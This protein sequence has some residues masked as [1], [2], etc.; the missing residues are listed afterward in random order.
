MDIS[1]QIPFS[2]PVS[3]RNVTKIAIISGSLAIYGDPV[4]GSGSS[5]FL[6]E[7]SEG[8]EIIL[9]EAE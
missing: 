7:L 2:Y 3:I 6:A 9:D 5:V 4:E 1:L 8:I